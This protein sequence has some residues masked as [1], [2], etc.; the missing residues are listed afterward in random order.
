MEDLHHLRLMAL[1][2]ELVEGQGRDESGRRTWTWTTGPS[3]ASLDSG[4]LSRRDAD[5]PKPGPAGRGRGLE[6]LRD[7]ER[8][9]PVELALLEEHGLTLP[10]QTY[11]LRGLTGAARPT[12]AGWPW[13]RPP[14]PAGGGKGSGGSLR[15]LLLKLRRR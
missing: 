13:R 1:L 12:G 9:M 11:P 5:G 8:L 10:P 6:W 7:E 3:R 14:R 2:D 4:R 15:T